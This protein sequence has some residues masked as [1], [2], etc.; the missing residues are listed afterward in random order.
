MSINTMT[1]VTV[2]VGVVWVRLLHVVLQLHQRF[3]LELLD[4]PTAVHT[5]VISRAT[6]SCE[7]Q[8]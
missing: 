6:H 5:W 4:L 3:L 7:H 8:L 2:P 1:S